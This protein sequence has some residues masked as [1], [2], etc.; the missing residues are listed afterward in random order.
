MSQWIVA[1]EFYISDI[2]INIFYIYI[3]FSFTFSFNFTSIF[4]ILL[5][6]IH[7]YTLYHVCRQIDM[8]FY[9]KA[10]DI[11][12]KTPSLVCVKVSLAPARVNEMKIR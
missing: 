5:Y 3:R 10:I 4:I 2:N 12:L 11:S 7:I 1:I 9:F 6:Y 8:S